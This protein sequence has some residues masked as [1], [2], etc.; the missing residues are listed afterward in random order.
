MN[1]KSRRLSARL[2]SFASGC[3][4]QNATITWR[5]FYLSN[6]RFKLE[7]VFGLFFFVFFRRCLQLCQVRRIAAKNGLETLLHLV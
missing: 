2:T 6:I 7:Y 5:R 1:S 4:H 3:R